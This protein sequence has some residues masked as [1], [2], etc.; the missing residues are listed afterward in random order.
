[1]VEGLTRTLRTSASM[2]QVGVSVMAVAM[3]RE[4]RWGEARKTGPTGFRIGIKSEF[5]V[6]GLGS[7]GK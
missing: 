7:W 6:S 1:M 4:A 3:G 5:K 2:W